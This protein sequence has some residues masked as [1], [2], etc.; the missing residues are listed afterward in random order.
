MRSGVACFQEDK[1]SARGHNPI[2]ISIGLELR[3]LWLAQGPQ[4]AATW[5]HGGLIFHA[6]LGLFGRADING[7]DAKYSPVR[8]RR[9]ALAARTAY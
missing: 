3:E 7:S 5:A 4:I 1:P 2:Y 6:L 9:I 8:C